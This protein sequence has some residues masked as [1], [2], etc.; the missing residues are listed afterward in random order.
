MEHTTVVRAEG[1]YHAFPVLHRLDDGRLSIGCVSS[2]FGDHWCMGGWSVLAST[3]DGKSWSRSDDPALPANWPGERPRE[4]Y[5]RLCGVLP[6]GTFMAVGSIGQEPWDPERRAE[7]EAR[8][9]RVYDDDLLSGAYDGKLVVGGHRLAVIRSA[10]RGASW[11]RRTWTVPGYASVVGFP[12]GTVLEDGTWL[13]PIYATTADGG[14]DGLLF[15]SVDGGDTWQ[16][17]LAVPRIC[18]EWALVETAPGRVLGHIR[19]EPSW[20]QPLQRHMYTLEVWSTDGG[21]AWTQPVE[22]AFEGYPSHLLKLRDGRLLCSFGYRR[23]PMGVRALISEDGGASWD[24]D[25]EYVLR[26]DA[27]TVS[28]EWP[29]EFRRR[30]SGGA[31]VGYPLS[32]ELED[33][34]I[35]TAYYITPADSTTHVAV[36]HWHPDADRPA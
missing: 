26:D 7:A 4:Q 13:F 8:G 36:T 30:S 23:Q 2:P 17:H 10:D 16:L 9:L 29:E 28:N 14:C 33:G 19:H 31:D 11:E 1:M 15:R 24:I 6:D 5:D 25:H 20:G 18:S 35:M 21:Q 12:R 3:D 32:V 22:T 27:G 34:R